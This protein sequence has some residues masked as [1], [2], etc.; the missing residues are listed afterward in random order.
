M[1]KYKK[2]HLFDELTHKDILHSLYL[3]Q[4]SLL[5]F[6]GIGI[7]LLFDSF[8]DFFRLFDWSDWRLLFG[9]IGGLAVV[10]LDVCFMKWLPRC[11]FDDGGINQKLFS[12]LSI[13]SIIGVTAL[14]AFTEEMFFR[15]VLQTQFGFLAA[16][17]LFALAHIRYL[18]NWFLTV[19]IF[20]LSFGFSCLYE[21]TGNLAVTVVMH[22]VID[23]GLGM[24]IRFKEKRKSAKRDDK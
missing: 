20:F 4:C 11:Y 19:N 14:I 2:V 22:F 17:I 16:S 10:L 5:A 9:A 6:T 23:C 24:I 8:F 21:W 18:S 7:Y 12:H 13:V 3:T 1:K 15:G